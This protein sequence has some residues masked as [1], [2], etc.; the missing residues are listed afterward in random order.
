MCD[1][2]YRVGALMAMSSLLIESVWRERVAIKSVL[3]VH[4]GECKRLRLSVECE[5]LH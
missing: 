1:R 3:G 4:L 5:Y 2:D